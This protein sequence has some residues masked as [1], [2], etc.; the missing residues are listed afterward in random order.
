MSTDISIDSFN[1]SYLAL[2]VILWVRSM[3]NKARHEWTDC[4]GHGH[5][6]RSS[7]DPTGNSEQK[8]GDYEQGTH[9]DWDK[10][11]GIGSTKFEFRESN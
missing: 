10:Q 5:L 7:H 8:R 11:C 4:K 6:N 1:R 3:G 2:S 9:D